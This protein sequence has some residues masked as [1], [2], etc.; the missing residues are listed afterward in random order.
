MKRSAPLALLFEWPSRHNVH[1]ALPLMMVLAFLFHVGG[2]FLFQASYPTDTRPE[3]RSAQV[4]FLRPGSPE[5]ASVMPLIT[6]RDPGLFSPSSS[7]E[8]DIWKLPATEYTPSFEKV[9]PRMEAFPAPP[10]EGLDRVWS[11]APV[12]YPSL[13]QQIQAS[14]LVAAPTRIVGADELHARSFDLLS[15]VSFSALEQQNLKPTAFLVAVAPEGTVK[16]ALPQSSSGNETLDAQALSAL[17]K[18]KFSPIQADRDAW[19]IISF[20]WGSDVTRQTAP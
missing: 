8:R 6:A 5:A 18:G 11:P 7:E 3:I 16:Y 20:Y 17:R 12:A 19:G 13:H 14:K 9:R 15:D 2:I 1:L 4:Y 10:P